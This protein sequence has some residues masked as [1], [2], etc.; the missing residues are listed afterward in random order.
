M[1]VFEFV[2][3]LLLNYRVS[4]ALA[5]EDGPFDLFSRIQGAFSQKSWLGRGL[6]CPL[7]VSFWLA[8]PAALLLQP[9]DW[10]SGFLL[11]GGI[12]GG[13]VIISRVV[14]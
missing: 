8:V 14:G 5:L 12:A 3:A 10:R 1:N 9:P 4:R 6:N 2:L 11:W 7:C 13:T